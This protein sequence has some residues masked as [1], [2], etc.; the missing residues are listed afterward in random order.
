MFGWGVF[1]FGCFGF[2]G[3]FFFISKNSIPSDNSLINQINNIEEMH[4]M[5]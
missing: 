1:G 4:A 2:A 5:L 3:F